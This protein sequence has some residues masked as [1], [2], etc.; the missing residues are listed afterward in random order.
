M[1]V[2]SLW[3][4]LL[5]G[6]CLDVVKAEKGVL[7][8]IPHYLHHLAC[9][10]WLSVC[11]CWPNDLDTAITGSSRYCLVL[12]LNAPAAS[13]QTIKQSVTIGVHSM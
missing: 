2:E 5:H 1:F 7:Q 11:V 13:H 4:S 6:L 9:L 3:M 10:Y 8:G 12:Q